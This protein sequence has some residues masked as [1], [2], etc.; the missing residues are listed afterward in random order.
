MGVGRLIDDCCSTPDRLMPLPEALD[1]IARSL[2]PVTEATRVPLAAALGR[3]LAEDVESPVSLPPLDNSAMDGYAVRAADLAPEGETVLPVTARQAAGRPLE[4]DAAAPG[5]A[6]RI[7]TG[8]PMP[9]GFDT[10]VMQEDVTVEEEGRIRLPVGIR[11]GANVRRAGEDVT[12]GSVVLTAGARVRAQDVAMAA[13]VG[14]ADLAVARPL[15][16]AIFSTGDE[17]RDPGQPLPAGCIYDSNRHAMAALLAGLP[18]TV[19][20]LGCLPDR[21]ETVEAALR[22]AAPVHDL[23]ITSGGVSVGEEDHVRAVVDRLGALTF[24]RLAVK[25]G[26]PAALG[27]IGDTVFL[28]LPGNPVATTVTFLLIAR[29]IILR[30][31]GAADGTLRRV[32]VP[33]AFSYRKKGSR[34]EFVRVTLADDGTGRTV[35]QALT[36]Q[37]SH[38]ISSVV[39]ANAMAE[40]PESCEGVAPGDLLTVIPFP[41]TM[42]G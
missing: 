24:W 28:G 5:G 4:G 14:R 41:D 16:V 19:T 39:Q 15:R 27:R 25:P 2:E 30:L 6:V 12:A 20:D 33:A 31:C 34:R 3:V 17:L 1:V 37:G 29:P 23:I 40:L 11:P 10:V 26:K 9:A 42:A 7:F 36:G 35:A 18:V 38:M 32:Q 21:P 8:A 13:A 22:E